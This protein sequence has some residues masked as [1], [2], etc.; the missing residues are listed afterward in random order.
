LEKAL[1][2]ADN[3]ARLKKALVLKTKKNSGNAKTIM[4]DRLTAANQRLDAYADALAVACR[5]RYPLNPIKIGKVA[6]LGFGLG[7]IV[8]FRWHGMKQSRK[9]GP[10]RSVMSLFSPKGYGGASGTL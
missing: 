1:S 5:D 2:P 8:D 10:E 4:R 6:Y 9:K 7:A 3:D